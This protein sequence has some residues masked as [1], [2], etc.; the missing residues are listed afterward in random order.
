MDLW[1]KRGEL[2]WLFQCCHANWQHN[3]GSCIC[4]PK[5]VGGRGDRDAAF[6][7][8]LGEKTSSEDLVYFL[9]RRV[10][11]TNF[12]LCF[13]IHWLLC[14]ALNESWDKRHKFEKVLQG[15]FGSIIVELYLN[16]SDGLSFNTQSVLNNWIYKT[17][18]STDKTVVSCFL[19]F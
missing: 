12:S 10:S 2:G 13:T 6:G 18:K 5:R 3:R 9:E 16:V 14:I 8:S 4:K 15:F 7:A 11:W 19:S 1:K 17:E